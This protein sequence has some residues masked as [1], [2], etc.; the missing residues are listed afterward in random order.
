MDAM[1]VVFWVVY[2]GTAA[3]TLY[4]ADVYRREVGGSE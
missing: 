1:T 2:V 3:L 4:V